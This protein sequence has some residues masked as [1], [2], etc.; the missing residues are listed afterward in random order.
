[1][2]M[3][4]VPVAISNTSEVYRAK[5][6]IRFLEGIYLFNFVAGRWE[7]ELFSQEATELVFIG[8]DL[9]WIKSE[10]IDR[11]KLCEQ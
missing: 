10:I 3:I 2:A 7:L 9:S 11:L 1:M 6:F 5:G 4:P 8:K